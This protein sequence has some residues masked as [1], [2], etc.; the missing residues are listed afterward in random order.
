[1]NWQIIVGII[2]LI[3]G[4]GN[5]INDFGAFVFGVSVGLVFLY[6]GLKKKGLIKKPTPQKESDCRT[7]VEETFHAVGV[8]YYEDNIRK[9]ACSNPDWKLTSS[10]IVKRGKSGKRI[11]RYYYVN[12][13]VKLQ[14]EPDN[15]HD[16]NAISVIIAGELVGYISREENVH[17]KDILDHREIISLSGFIGGGE[18]KTVTDY[19]NE[20]KDEIGLTVNVRIKYI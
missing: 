6:F 9:L 19:G 12:K 3:G 10:Q 4:V 18:C 7:L 8:C 13:P 15:P 11:F 16:E 1:M 17:V 14:I 20:I 2:F 5:L